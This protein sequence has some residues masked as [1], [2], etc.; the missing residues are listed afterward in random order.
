MT[1]T[2]TGLIWMRCSL[3][4]MWDGAACSGTAN[5]YTW[6]AALQA[7]FE[8]NS[9]ASN[10]DGDGLAGFANETDWRLPNRNELESI[11]ERRCCGAVPEHSVDFVLVVFT[12]CQ[13]FL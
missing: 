3:G 12:S 2:R 4:Q 5:T 13:Q 7:A 1:D 6:Q 8:I 10:D 9:G 11:V